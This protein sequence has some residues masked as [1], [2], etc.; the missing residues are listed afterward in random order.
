MASQP[1][2]RGSQ[3]LTAILLMAGAVAGVVGNSLDT[4]SA[5]SVT[6]T[7]QSIVGSPA[8]V[9]VHLTIIVAVLL[10]IGGLVGLAHLLDD[11]PAGALAR[12][13][14]AAA[15]LGG[16]IVTVSTAVDG[17]VMKSLALDWATAP[18]SEAA[19]ALRLAGAVNLVDFG[20]WSAGMLVLFGMAFACFGAALVVSG[21]FP[22]WLGWI[23][24]ASGVGSF[25][26]A[27]MQIANGGEVQAAE[28]LFLVTSMLITL[29]AFAVGVLLWRSASESGRLSI[30]G[31]S[32]PTEQMHRPATTGG[33]RPTAGQVGVGR[34]GLNEASAESSSRSGAAGRSSIL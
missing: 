10:V 3:R 2:H 28:T 14:L 17:F 34:L 6:L 15:L 5:A 24:V 21:R 26:A 23:A 31:P 27:L 18:A 19:T 11:G 29:W 30:P 22:A 7:L 32:Q 16:A 33:D 9:A 12:L 1:V 13:G 4:H 20:I 8:Y 25:V